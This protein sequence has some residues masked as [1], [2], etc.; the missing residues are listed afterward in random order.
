MVGGNDVLALFQELQSKMIAF[1]ASFVKQQR[2]ES[3]HMS[4]LLEERDRRISVLEEMVDS[5]R[6]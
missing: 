3:A 4:T 6:Q 2:Q 1:E 5:L